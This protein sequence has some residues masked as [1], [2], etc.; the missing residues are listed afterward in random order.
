MLTDYHLPRGFP[1]GILIR[2][3]AVPLVEGWCMS[4]VDEVHYLGRLCDSQRTSFRLV[5]QLAD[6]D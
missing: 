5:E 6:V 2:S 3:R 4:G 1:V